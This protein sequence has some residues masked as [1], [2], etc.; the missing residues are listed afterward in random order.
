MSFV[1]SP[2]ARRATCGGVLLRDDAII[3]EATCKLMFTSICPFAQDVACH[4]VDV[5]KQFIN[6]CF[7]PEQEFELAS[8]FVFP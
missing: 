7:Y 6:P 4:V 1:S 8:D 3:A 5:V 2:L